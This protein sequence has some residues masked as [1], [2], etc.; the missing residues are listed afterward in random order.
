MKNVVSIGRF[1]VTSGKLYVGDPCYA[2]HRDSDYLTILTSVEN[3]W[4]EAKVAK[5]NFGTWGVRNGVLMCSCINYDPD[6]KVHQ[7][8]TEN[9][10]IGVDSGSVCVFDKKHVIGRPEAKHE[11]WYDMVGEAHLD[12]KESAGVMSH[13]AASSSGIGDGMYDLKYGRNIFGKVV[14]VRVNFA[15][16]YGEGKQTK[17]W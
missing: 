8:M 13:G 10:V 6:V 5:V 11:A 14:A 9:E 2:K 3:G 1:Q 12:A 15:R 4:W 17:G 7:W 16:H